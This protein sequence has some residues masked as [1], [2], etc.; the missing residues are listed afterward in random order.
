MRA[1]VRAC[2]RVCDTVYGDTEWRHCRE[3]DETWLNTHGQTCIHYVAPLV[4]SLMFHYYMPCFILL[5]LAFMLCF[6][7][8]VV[9]LVHNGIISMQL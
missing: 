5:F 3:F 6:R 4:G 2:V 7:A 8:F 1:C 9:G